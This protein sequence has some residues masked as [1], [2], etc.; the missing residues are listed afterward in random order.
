MLVFKNPR[1]ANFPISSII[2]LTYLFIMGS[3]LFLFTSQLI[4]HLLF[5]SLAL[6]GHGTWHFRSSLL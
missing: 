2:S 3:L 6:L 4:P 1:E 5:P